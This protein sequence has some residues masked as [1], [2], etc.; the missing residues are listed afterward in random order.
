MLNSLATL[1]ALQSFPALP[2]LLLPP[3]ILALPPSLSRPQLKRPSPENSPGPLHSSCAWGFSLLLYAFLEQLAVARVFSGAVS[4]HLCVYPL[5]S[6]HAPIPD[7]YL[8]GSFLF[9]S[10][11]SSQPAIPPSQE[12]PQLAP[13]SCPRAFA[14]MI[15]SAASTFQPLSPQLTQSAI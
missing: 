11:L 14:Q 3:L 10:S 12:G 13:L 9:S 2:F 6:T 8:E 1:E 4:G 7:C 15:S 5:L